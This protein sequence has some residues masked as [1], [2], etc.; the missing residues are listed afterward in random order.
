MI[1]WSIETALKS[2]LFDQVIVSTDDLTIARVAKQYG[3]TAPFLRPEVLSD[4]HAPTVPVVSHAIESAKSEFDNL[5]GVCCLYATAPF[6]RASDLRRGWEKLQNSNSDYAVSVTS[7]SY[8]VQR[9]LLVNGDGRMRMAWP[10]YVETRSQDLEQHYHD[11]GQFYWGRPE[12]WLNQRPLLG[13]NNTA[14]ILPPDR[15]QDIDDMTDWK[16]AES[17]FRFL[18]DNKKI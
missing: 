10:E 18:S 5:N 6:V 3:A 8:P 14:V 4:D 13:S 7:F 12:T 1:G 11:A 15:V 2:N 17:L 16:R 9:A